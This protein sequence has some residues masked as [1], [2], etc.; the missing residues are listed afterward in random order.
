MTQAGERPTVPLDEFLAAAERFLD[1][2]APR[3]GAASAP[4]GTGAD[5]V[6]F[7][8]RSEV[9]ARSAVAAARQWLRDQFDAGFG[10]ITGP[11]ER[12]GAGLPPSYERAYLELRKRYRI[13]DLF[14][15]RTGA[16]IVAPSLLEAA[17]EDVLDEVLVPILRGDLVLC[18]LFSEPDAGSDL[19]NIQTRAR[20]DGDEFVLNGQKVWSSGAHYSDLGLCLARTASDRGKHGGISAFLVDIRAAGVELRSIRQINGATEF[21]EVFLTDVAVPAKRLVGELHGGWAVVGEILARERA[22]IGEERISDQFYVDRLLAL[23]RRTDRVGDPQTRADVARAYTSLRLARWLPRRLLAGVAVDAA[24]GPELGLAKLALCRAL[25]DVDRAATG[26]VGIASVVETLEWGTRVW[27][28]FSVGWRGSA[29]GGGTTEVV[30]N[31]VAERVLGLPRE[32]RIPPSPPA[33]R[34]P[35]P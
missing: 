13:P 5:A 7:A 16:T 18:Q 27:G 32:P 11:V 19:A 23:V 22:A 17:D 8:A 14:P 24:P 20:R 26:M 25:A 33:E 35:S 30:R 2:H 28:D 1:A 10:W 34:L 4:W 3:L 6:G 12:G 29:I 9:D 21:D 15:V 31:G